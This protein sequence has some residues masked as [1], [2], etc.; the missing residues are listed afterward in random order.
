MTANSHNHVQW[1]FSLA[2]TFHDENLTEIF[3]PKHDIKYQLM[4]A[5]DTVQAAEILAHTYSQENM[6]FK[7]IS[8]SKE[9]YQPV[10]LS[11]F[12]EAVKNNVAIVAKSSDGDVA[13]VTGAY[14]FSTAIAEV[15][16]D[17]EDLYGK[18]VAPIMDIT[19]LLL[20]NFSAKDYDDPNHILYIDGTCVSSQYRGKCISLMLLL[21]LQS[22]GQRQGYSHVCSVLYHPA[23]TRNVERMPDWKKIRTIDIRDYSYQNKNIFSQ[24]YN[25]SYREVSLFLRKYTPATS[26]YNYNLRYY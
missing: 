1:C 17:L 9:D 24:L 12:N 22:L 23:L 11:R 4:E 8:L 10:A 19:R 6:F 15:C 25:Q 14:L 18:K 21:L 16:T 3:D 5:S 13:G 2:K 7:A 26:N 20:E